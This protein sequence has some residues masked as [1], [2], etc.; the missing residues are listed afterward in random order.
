MIETSLFT[1]VFEYFL[2][3]YDWYISFFSTERSLL[4]TWHLSG[5]Q[6]VFSTSIRGLLVVKLATMDD[7]VHFGHAEHSPQIKLE[8][9]NHFQK[10]NMQ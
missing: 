10:S 7:S 1:V 4:V 6:G 8:S 2:Y 9:T 3:T 5:F